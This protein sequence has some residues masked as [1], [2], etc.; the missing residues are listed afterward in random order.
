[1]ERSEFLNRYNISAKAFASTGISWEELEKVREHYLK[2][3]DELEPTARGIVNILHKTEKVHSVSYRIKEPEHLMAKIIRKRIDKPQIVIDVDNYRQRITDLIGI[4][5]L[6]LFKED[7]M[8]IN[9]F[10][11]KTWDLQKAPVAYVRRG[12]AAGYIDSFKTNGCLIKEHPYGYRSVHYL[13]KSTAAEWGEVSEVQ[14][15]TLFEEAWSSID[16]H[17]RYPYEPRNILLN[18]LLVILNRLAGSADEMGSYIIYLKKKLR[19]M[20]KYF[21]DND[22]GDGAKAGFQFLDEF[23]WHAEMG[24]GIGERE[25]SPS[26]E[27]DVGEEEPGNSEKSSSSRTT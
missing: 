22:Y 23:E 16:H 1:M 10:I 18:E 3:R 2:T 7:W 15:R 5:V 14:V 17:V 9:S 27:H 24:R 26:P 6:H 12:D 11:I 13:L 20:D 8:D 19:S 4:R 21:T 25:D